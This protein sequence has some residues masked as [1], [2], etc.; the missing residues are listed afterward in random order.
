MFATLLLLLSLGFAGVWLLLRLRIVP[1][2]FMRGWFL[3]TL[4]VNCLIIGGF[5][6]LVEQTARFGVS[7]R[8]RK[9]WNSYP[10]CLCFQALLL[11]NPQLHI[12]IDESRVKVRDIPDHSAS[13]MN[14]CSR[15][16]PIMI[17]GATPMSFMWNLRTYFAISLSHIPVF[18]AGSRPHWPLPRA[19]PIG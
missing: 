16:D 13:A 9:L 10:W 11:L 2:W 18:G 14:H 12:T 6:A 1:V 5:A 7:P 8:T 19:L 15:F 3:L 17:V 4:S